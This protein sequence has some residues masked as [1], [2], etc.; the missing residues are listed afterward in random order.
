MLS[1]IHNYF[2]LLILVLTHSLCLALFLHQLGLHCILRLFWC[3]DI[4]TWHF[5]QCF[6]GLESGFQHGLLLL[7]S[8]LHLLYFIDAE[9][10]EL[11]TFLSVVVSKILNFWVVDVSHSHFICGCLEVLIELRLVERVIASCVDV[12]DWSIVVDDI[13]HFI[14]FLLV[15]AHFFLL[16]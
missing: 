14:S 5:R 16:S 7:D 6:P 2:P 13:W 3:D 4:G 12:D 8:S 9:T 11:W 10:L 15:T 1:L